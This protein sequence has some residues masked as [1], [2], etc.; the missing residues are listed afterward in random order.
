MLNPDDIFAANY[1]TL[2]GLVRERNRP[3][4]GIRTLHD[5]AQQCFLS[6]EKLVLEVGCNTGFSVVNLAMLTGAVIHG[7][8]LNSLSIKEAIRYAADSGVTSSTVFK[9][10]SALE[11]PYPDNYF[12]ALWVSNVTSF[13]SDKTA[14]LTEYFRVLKPF[15]YL[16]VAPIYYHSTPPADLFAEV[17]AMI[18]TD[19]TIRSLAE[20]KQTIL[21]SAERAGVNAV[22]CTVTNYRYHDQSGYIDEWLKLIL[23]KPHLQD[24]SVEMRHCL[25]ER[26][27]KCMHLFNENLKYCSYS[28]LLYQKRLTAEEPELFYT[29]R[30]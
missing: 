8:D 17:E 2:V 27:S 10:G 16:G 22:E 21:L 7:V 12:D 26:Y 4:G 6:R 11:I 29:E 1:S 14:A 20:W 13:I 3:S 15:G 5:F 24:L 19:L 25:A 9:V 30:A 23:N 18:G 28:L